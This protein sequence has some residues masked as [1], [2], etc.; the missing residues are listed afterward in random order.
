MLHCE[1][2]VLCNYPNRYYDRTLNVDADEHAEVID[3]LTSFG[4][5]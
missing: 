4:P 1:F 3:A 2:C 5:N